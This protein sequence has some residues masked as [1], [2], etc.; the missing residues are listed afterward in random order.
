M[1][2]PKR[3][4]IKNKAQIDDR[5]AKGR[6]A[7]EG[8]DPDEYVPFLNVHDI[9][10][11]GRSS[12]VKIGKRVAHTHSDLETMCLNEL[13]WNPNVVAIYEQVALDG[14]RTEEIARELGIKHP[15]LTGDGETYILTTDLVAE[16]SVQ[17]FS[18]YHAIAVKPVSAIDLGPYL[19]GELTDK[20]KRSVIERTIAK[21]EIERRYWSEQNYT[22]LLVTDA[23]LSRVRNF[24]INV[25][26]TARKLPSRPNHVEY[27]GKVSLEVLRAIK[28]QPDC[29]IQRIAAGLEKAFDIPPADV[30][31]MLRHLCGKRL[32][33]FD[34]D[35]RFGPECHGRDFVIPR[36]SA[37]DHWGLAA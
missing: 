30:I 35:V 16:I 26:L 17:G 29:Q 19:R 21:L 31:D 12:R 7:H 33:E 22:W 27:W 10:S 32:I 6:G 8:I 13:R 14:K 28:S 37:A 5:I 15:T 36:K 1:A 24:N 4:R 23:V 20:R 25:F 34:M 9:S 2:R 3:S 18:R 11:V